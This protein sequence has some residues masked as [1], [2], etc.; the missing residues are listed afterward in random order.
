[1]TM[2]RWLDRLTEEEIAAHPPLAVT[3]AMCAL[4]IGN[5]SLVERWTSVASQA[6]ER[7]GRVD[8]SPALEAG[9]ALLRAALAREGIGPM[10]EEAARAYELLPDDNPWRSVSCL[11]EGVAR[12]VSG[13]QEGGRER[14]REGARRAAAGNAPDVHALCLAQLAL[15]GGGDG[16]EGVQAA[17]RAERAGL[18]DFADMALVFAASADARTQH[19]DVD[20]GVRDL[21]RAQLLLA[22]L[23]DNYLPW[24]LLET[25][26]LLARAALRL[27]DV[28][29]ARKLLAEA[30]GFLR[31]LPDAVALVELHDEIREQADAVL[32]SSAGSASL[33]TAEMRVLQLLPTHLPFGEIAQRLHLSTNT[34][35]T[36]AHSAYRKLD[37]SSRSE[38]VNRARALGLLDEDP[39]G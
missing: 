14:L 21:K 7:V 32:K 28:S 29:R 33:T 35:K 10:G 36:Q 38:A 26:L 17:V 12:H 18:A 27:S 9:V 13:D 8:R 3:A 22:M 25:R 31:E 4:N 23:G 11:F 34:V 6:L 1:M 20:G 5:G 24:Y 37:S 15:L 16:S 19:G 39:H 30:R 2:Q